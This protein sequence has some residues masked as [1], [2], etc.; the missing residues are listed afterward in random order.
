M[1]QIMSVLTIDCWT[2]LGNT[3]VV[4]VTTIQVVPHSNTIAQTEGRTTVTPSIT[5]AVAGENYSG[6]SKECS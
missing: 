4:S 6:I 5:L 2:F 1:T 3:I